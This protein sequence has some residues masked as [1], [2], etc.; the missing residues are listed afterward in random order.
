MKL[1]QDEI[2]LFFKLH[3]HLLLYVNRQKNVIGKVSSVGNLRAVGPDKLGRIRE[4]LLKDLT[5]IDSF[6]REN[7]FFFAENELKIVESWKKGIHD[8]F[9]IVKYDKEHTIFYHPKTKKCYGVLY[10]NDSFEDVLGPYLPI[11]VRAWLIPLNGKIIY[12][13]LLNPYPI[14]FGGGMRKSLKAEYEEAIVRQGVITSFDVQQ[15]KSTSD[16]ELLR[17]YMKSEANRQRYWNEI[18]ELSEKSAE[19][20]KTYHQELGKVDSRAIK[21]K[22]KSIGIKDKWFAVLEGVVITTGNTKQELLANISN[23]LPEEKK[24]LV[25]IFKV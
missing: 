6:R 7:P 21:K 24:E 8:L 17:F 5:L 25:Y 14:T 3:D 11:Y 16:E 22:L 20:D 18:V 12:D 2:G 19:L 9:F 13:G 23:T 1:K 10:L 15:E 4:K